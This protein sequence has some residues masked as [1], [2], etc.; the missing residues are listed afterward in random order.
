MGKS[1]KQDTVQFRSFELL[2]AEH[3][4]VFNN[5][6]A[7][8]AADLVGLK[9]VSEVEIRLTL[10]HCKY[11]SDGKVSG[12][13][14]NLYEVCGQAQK[15][16]VVKHE[17]LPKLATSLRKRR[18]KWAK[19]NVCFVRFEVIR[20]TE[21]PQDARMSALG[22]CVAAPVVVVND[23]K[24]PFAQLCKVCFLRRFQR[25]GATL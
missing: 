5:D 3:D 2:E 22:N 20:H 6:G 16:I 15:S 7:G 9:E 1:N 18:E 25:V 21:I 8:E 4:V 13:I 17:G 24:G 23:R 14:A 12:Q 19:V 10:I 11:A